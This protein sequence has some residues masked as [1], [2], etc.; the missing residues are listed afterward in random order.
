MRDDYASKLY[1]TLK[2]P[3]LPAPNTAE[4]RSCLNLL[5]NCFIHPFKQHNLKGIS[6]ATPSHESTPSTPGSLSSYLDSNAA[7]P[8]QS[9]FK[10]A[11]I[12][13]DQVCLCCWGN[14]ALEA[15]HFIAQ[16]SGTPRAEDLLS[17]AGLD[18]IFRVQNGVLLCALCH[19]EFD[20]LKRYFDFVDGGTGLVVKV[21]NSTNDPA[22]KQYFDDVGT[23]K[24]IRSFKLISLDLVAGRT[25][26]D[27]DNELPVYFVDNDE[28]KYPKRSALAFHKAACLIWKMTGGSDETSDD[29]AGESDNGS[30]DNLLAKVCNT[31]QGLVNVGFE[32]VES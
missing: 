24:A 3:S 31:L 2:T 7:N 28:R 22:N 19:T 18:D 8:G 11:L 32:E 23:I 20:K 17:R 12:K 1:W 10:A 25:V 26:V 30:V 27:T 16:K 21:V 14:S 29:F 4:E 15:A 6:D 9:N 13:R 5:Y